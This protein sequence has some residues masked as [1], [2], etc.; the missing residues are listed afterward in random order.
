MHR[1]HII[2]ARTV[3][4]L[5]AAGFTVVGVAPLAMAGESAPPVPAPKVECVTAVQPC[6]GGDAK[7]RHRP[8]PPTTEIPSGTDWD[9]AQ[10][11]LGA[12]GGIALAAAAVTGRAGLRRHH[13]TVHQH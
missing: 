9:A 1:I 6:T 12:L 7:M 5:L 8:C 4:G 11:A 3:G 13:R 2:V 10:L